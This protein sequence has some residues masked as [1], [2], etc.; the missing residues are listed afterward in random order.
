[1]VHHHSTMSNNEHNIIGMDQAVEIIEGA[2]ES[3]RV[4]SVRFVKRTDNTIRDMNC[5]GGVRKHLRG[6]ELAYD[7][8]KK[9]LVTV[10]DMQKGGY[11]SINCDSIMQIVVDGKT[12]KI[13]LG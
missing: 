3:G 10:F 1:M 2:K 11:R 5:R 7:P 8:K 4:F 12:F 6:G 13:E 9:R